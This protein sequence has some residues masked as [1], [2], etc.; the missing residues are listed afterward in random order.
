MFAKAVLLLLPVIP[1]L[2]A[3]FPGGG[4]H[5]HEEWDK[6]SCTPT[7]TT[8]ISTSIS[9]SIITTTFTTTSVT[10]ITPA[11][12]VGSQ[13]FR[14][15]RYCGRSTSTLNASFPPASGSLYVASQTICPSPVVIKGSSIG[16][17]GI[18]VCDFT[19]TVTPT[20]PTFVVVF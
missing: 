19:A 5:D 2:V 20:V 4:G 8:S 18:T 6:K 1:S 17:F 13:T 12:A 7:T 11:A 9:T 16:V 3:A 15:V 10:T 14:Y